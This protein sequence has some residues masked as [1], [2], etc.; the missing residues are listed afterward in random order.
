MKAIIIRYQHGDS[1]TIRIL[2]CLDATE[3]GARLLAWDAANHPAVNYEEEEYQGGECVD[4][5]E[6][7]ETQYRL[8]VWHDSYSEDGRLVASH[9]SAAFRFYVNH[10]LLNLVM[11]S[12]GRLSFRDKT[13]SASGNLLSSVEAA[14]ISPEHDPEDVEKYFDSF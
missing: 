13:D 14:L 5:S 9:S 7:L 10:V 8:A 4:V 3:R 12:D 1:E 11:D 2:G 6:K